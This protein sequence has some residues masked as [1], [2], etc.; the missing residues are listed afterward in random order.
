MDL[1]DFSKG[2]AWSIIPEKFEALARKFHD[3]K[4]SKSL[5]K[6]IAFFNEKQKEADL[7][8][9]KNGVAVIPITGSLSK[10]RSFFSWLF[11]GAS[12]PEIAESFAAALEDRDGAERLIRE[13]ERLQAE[14]GDH[15][16][17]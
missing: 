2:Q 10:R 9:I 3:F 6:N 1:V 14:T 13:I 15:E 16:G 12:Y 4:A 5:S 8:E 7:Y 11:G 17:S